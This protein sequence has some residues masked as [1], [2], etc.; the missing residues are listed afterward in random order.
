MCTRSMNQAHQLP[1]NV[2][3]SSVV[4]MTDANLPLLM[5]AFKVIAIHTVGQKSQLM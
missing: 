5:S 1:E 2:V 3:K 4:N